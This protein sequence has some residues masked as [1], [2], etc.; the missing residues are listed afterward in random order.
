MPEIAVNRYRNTII[1]VIEDPN[2]NKNRIF[3]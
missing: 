3:I 2:P 1:P